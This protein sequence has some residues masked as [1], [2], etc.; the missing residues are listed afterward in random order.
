MQSCEIRDETAVGA[1]WDVLVLVNG[2][3]LFSRRCVD[4]RQARYVAESLRQDNVRGGWTTQG[5][6][7]TVATDFF[8]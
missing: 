6:A 1:G 2:E 8:V 3:P 5:T 4:D 7:C